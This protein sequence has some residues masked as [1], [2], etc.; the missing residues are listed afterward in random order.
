MSSQAR[1]KQPL[2][3]IAE[4]VLRNIS[5][6]FLDPKDHADWVAS[7]M[8]QWISYDGRAAV[9]TPTDR[10]WLRL[11]RKSDG[12][13]VEVTHKSGG[14]LEPFFK[15]WDVEPDLSPSILAELNL[16]QVAEFQNRAGQKLRLRVEPHE[17]K[18][19]IEQS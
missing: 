17:R 11:I 8:R 16:L 3:M 7:I 18:V 13:K 1:Q 6:G 2:R 9:F 15:D 12:Y 10:F 19:S 14:P 5:R 4:D